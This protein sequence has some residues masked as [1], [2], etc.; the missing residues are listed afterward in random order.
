MSFYK[1]LHNLSTAD[2]YEEGTSRKRVSRATKEYYEIERVIS[3]RVRQGKV[4]FYYDRICMYAYIFNILHL[5]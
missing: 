5:A 2:F 4:G 1:A 3:R